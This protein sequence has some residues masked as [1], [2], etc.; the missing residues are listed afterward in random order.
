MQRTNQRYVA[1]QRIPFLIDLFYFAHAHAQRRHPR[2]VDHGG[3]TVASGIAFRKPAPGKNLDQA[4]FFIF[5]SGGEAAFQHS[6]QRSPICPGDHGNIL[7][8]L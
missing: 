8:A 6:V 2:G 1:Q 5:V 3:V 7:R 4:F